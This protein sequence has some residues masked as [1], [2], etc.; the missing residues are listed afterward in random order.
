MDNGKMSAFFYHNHRLHAE[1]FDLSLIPE[2]Y[3]TP[4]FVYSKKQMS[5]NYLEL[6]NALKAKISPDRFMI[7]YATKA[8]GG[9]S[10]LKTLG[11]LGAG[12][13]IVSY[14]EM[15]RAL[16]AGI[17]AEK[18]I[19]SGV[20]KTDFEIT[21]ALKAGIYQINIESLP[22]LMRISELADA[23]SLRAAVALRV[24]PDVD[25]G[26]HEKITTGKKENKFGIDIDESLAIFKMAKTLPAIDMT[27]VAIH[28]GSQLLDI[29]PYETAFIRIVEL[30]HLLKAQ[31]I[32][33]SRID[34][35]GGMGITYHSEDRPLD[36]DAYAELVARYFSDIDCKLIFEPGRAIIGNAGILLSQALYIKKT[37]HKNYLILD[38]G[39]N[40]I[41]RPALYDAY[42]AI[43]PV[44]ERPQLVTEKYDVVGPICESS[45]VFLKNEIMPEIQAKEYVAIMNAGAYCA[46]MASHYNTRALATEVLVDNDQIHVM[47]MRETVDDLLKREIMF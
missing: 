43:I 7:A 1:N 37:A 27:G 42:H 16:H 21:E 22:E 4:T 19:F 17:S 11:A 2:T 20:G 39:M 29:A 13:D 3:G 36:L 33:L 31:G 45:D 5:Q 35:G 46:V 38:A 32:N 14:G 15:R 28:I 23:L 34:L 12:A 24:N 26:T 18:I 9:L 25:A 10:I 30:Y 6:Y 47:R 41:I 8:N 44:V 40:D